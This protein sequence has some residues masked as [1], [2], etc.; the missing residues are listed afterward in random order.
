LSGVTLTEAHFNQAT[1]NVYKKITEENI[2]IILDDYKWTS[3]TKIL[4]V[5]N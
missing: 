3:G 4:D 5:T 2:N 1:L